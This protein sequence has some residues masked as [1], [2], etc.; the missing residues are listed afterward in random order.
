MLLEYYYQ[1]RINIQAGSSIGSIQG[2]ISST[3]LWLIN[4]HQAVPCLLT[5]LQDVAAFKVLG[6]RNNLNPRICRLREGYN[7]IHLLLWVTF[8]NGYLFFRRIRNAQG[9]AKITSCDTDYCD[10]QTIVTRVLPSG[11]GGKLPSPPPPPSEKRVK[12]GEK[13]RGGRKGKACSF[14]VLQF[15]WVSLRPAKYLLNIID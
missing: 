8:R 13:E 9:P 7:Q 15:T 10:I 5:L 1:A 14:L 12:G 11:G 6:H 3:A 2:K 4:A